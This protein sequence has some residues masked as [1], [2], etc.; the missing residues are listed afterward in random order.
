MFVGFN[1]VP[2]SWVINC[3]CVLAHA[4]VCLFWG[5]MQ[6]EVSGF[7]ALKSPWRALPGIKSWGFTVWLRNELAALKCFI[8]FKR[9]G[10]NLYTVKKSESSTAS[11]QILGIFPITV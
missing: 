5:N 6:D 1:I 2:K 10:Q 3:V 7:E 11:F 8:F 9:I 4:R